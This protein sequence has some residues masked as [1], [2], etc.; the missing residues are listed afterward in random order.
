MWKIVATSQ[1]RKDSKRYQHSNDK[2]E[3][4]NSALLELRESGAVSAKYR[5]HRLSGNWSGH[6]EC[7]IQ[8]DFLL[9]W[10]DEKT[11]TIKLVRLGSHSELFGK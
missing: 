6:M 7:H 9:I 3:A 11:R 8:W 10:K 2:I 5:P 4:L 1:F